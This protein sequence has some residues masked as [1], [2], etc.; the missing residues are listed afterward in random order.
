MSN[1]LKKILIFEKNVIW[2]AFIEMD[3]IESAIK[4]RNALNDRPFFANSSRANI[5]FSDRETINFNNK[6]SNGFGKQCF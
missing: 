2:K 5:Y 4:A 6:N 3:S 1:N